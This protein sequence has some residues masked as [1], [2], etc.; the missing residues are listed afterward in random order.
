M[1]NQ[2]TYTT[3]FEKSKLQKEF[4]LKTLVY[5]IRKSSK[6]K[7]YAFVELALILYRKKEISSNSLFL[8]VVF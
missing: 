1:N 4:F 8:L 2:I 3:V 5:A 6:N 7:I